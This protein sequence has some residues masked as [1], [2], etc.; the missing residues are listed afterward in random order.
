MLQIHFN[1]WQFLYGILN[2]KK[3]IIEMIQMGQ[4]PTHSFIASHF[5]Q[6]HGKY[7]LTANNNLTLFTSKL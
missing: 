2:Q 5:G 6:E 3:K 4:K 7:L 1:M